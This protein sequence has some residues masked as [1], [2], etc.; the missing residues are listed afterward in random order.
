MIPAS[1]INIFMVNVTS[2]AVM[3]P[4]SEK[5]STKK[6]YMWWFGYSEYKILCVL[7]FVLRIY[8]FNIL[9]TKEIIDP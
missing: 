9:K 1:T 8:I 7:F 3:I 6:Y 2:S 5:K 4:V